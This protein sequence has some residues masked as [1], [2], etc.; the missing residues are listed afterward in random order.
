M[1]SRLHR[2][3]RQR[4]L[5]G[6]RPL[7]SLKRA[8]QARVECKPLAGVVLQHGIDNTLE[9]RR[10]LCHDSYAELQQSISQ[11]MLSFTYLLAT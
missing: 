6:E 2:P 11:H 7:G 4:P 5:H 1:F 9:V 10:M 8:F 3:V